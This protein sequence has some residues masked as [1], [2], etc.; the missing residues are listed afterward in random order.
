MI[1]PYK[2][3]ANNNQWESDHG[4]NTEAP[5]YGKMVAVIIYKKNRNTEEKSK[6][7]KNN[8]ACIFPFPGIN[9]DGQQNKGWNIV[10]QESTQLLPDCKSGCKN[11]P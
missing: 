7:D 4:D 6:Y 10:N 11:I 8:T 2:Q 3:D 1:T 5:A 9:E